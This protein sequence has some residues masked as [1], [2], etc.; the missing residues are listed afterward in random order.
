M[1]ITP[2]TI[3]I[4]VGIIVL[5]LL[6]L[7]WLMLGHRGGGRCSICSIRVTSHLLKLLVDVGA[8]VIKNLVSSSLD[9]HSLKSEGDSTPF[10][11]PP[12]MVRRQQKITARYYPYQLTAI[13]WW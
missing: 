2:N 8:L 6:T 12:N 3:N 4:K 11:D 9:T 5:F 1:T 10:P 13:G 7:R